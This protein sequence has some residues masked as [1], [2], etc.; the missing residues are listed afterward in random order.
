MYHIHGHLLIINK[1]IETLWDAQSYKKLHVL[2]HPRSPKKAVYPGFRFFSG[3][4]RPSCSQADL[5][6]SVLLVNRTT[7][8]QQNHLLFHGASAYRKPVMASLS[9]AVFSHF[10]DPLS[11][12]REGVTGWALDRTQRRKHHV[13]DVT[14]TFP[15]PQASR[16][17]ASRPGGF[18]FCLILFCLIPRSFLYWLRWWESRWPLW[19]GSGTCTHNLPAV[20]YLRCSFSSSFPAPEK[21]KL[22]R[23]FPGDALG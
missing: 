19:K 9:Q 6:L 17:Q 15:F 12:L 18:G 16:P 14:T 11:V 7:G 1:T 5:R 23:E 4:A 2:E 8:W 3:L 21:N 22:S 20:S 10:S 13:T